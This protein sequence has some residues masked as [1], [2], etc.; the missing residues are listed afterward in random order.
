[1]VGLRVFLFLQYSAAITIPLGSLCVAFSYVYGTNYFRL[2][3]PRYLVN[4]AK[5]H[6]SNSGIHP[7]DF[8]SVGGMSEDVTCCVCKKSDPL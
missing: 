3:D 2:R 4:S 5:G 6:C 7:D 8:G 1:M